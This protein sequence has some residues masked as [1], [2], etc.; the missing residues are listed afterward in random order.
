VTV[1]IDVRVVSVVSVTVSP[2]K[3]GEGRVTAQV[4]GAVPIHISVPPVAVDVA[5]PEPDFKVRTL[6]LRTVLIPSHAD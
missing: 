3:A 2:S 4:V 6:P 1:T 5:A